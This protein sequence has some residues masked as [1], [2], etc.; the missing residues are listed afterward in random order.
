M[1]F[2]IPA[3]LKPQKITIDLAGSDGNAYVLMGYAHSLGKALGLDK[4]HILAITQEMREKDYE[5]LLLVFEK[6]FGEYVNLVLPA[7]WTWSPPEG[8]SH[9]SEEMVPQVIEV[10]GHPTIK[11]R[12][13]RG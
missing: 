6:H 13:G 11:P 1:S 2:L 3:K 5:H 7:N 8:T 12:L 4:R 9:V 10:E